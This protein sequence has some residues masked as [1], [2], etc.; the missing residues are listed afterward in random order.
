MS[1]GVLSSCATRKKIDG[2]ELYLI[3]KIDIR[4]CEREPS[5]KKLGIFRKVNDDKEIFIS[6]C[7]PEIENF[8]SVDAKD[9]EVILNQFVQ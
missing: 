8:I 4:V 9:M 3:D 2:I 7:K 5:L 6:F 1:M